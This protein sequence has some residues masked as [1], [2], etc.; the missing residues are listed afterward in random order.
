MWGLRWGQSPRGWG[1]PL[2]TI[3]EYR[4]VKAIDR[5]LKL[6]DGNGFTSSSRRPCLQSSRLNYAIPAKKRDC[7][8]VHFR[9]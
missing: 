4:K 9:T 8:S 3:M 1:R 6:F 5:H 7:T 2:L